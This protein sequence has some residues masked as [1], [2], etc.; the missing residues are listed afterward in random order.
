MDTEWNLTLL[1]LSVPT[2]TLLMVFYIL[3]HSSVYCCYVDTKWN[4]P[5]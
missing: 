5:L 2:N 3:A 1:V 4:L